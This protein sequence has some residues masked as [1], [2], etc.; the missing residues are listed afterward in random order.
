MCFGVALFYK[1]AS[2]K[3]FGVSV[4]DNAKGLCRRLTNNSAKAIAG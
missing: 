3:A 2:P 1:I 4:L